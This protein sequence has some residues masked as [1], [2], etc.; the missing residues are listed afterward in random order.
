MH[1]HRHV[2]VRHM[3][4]SEGDGEGGGVPKTETHR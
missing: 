3:A 1:L 2:P 4:Q